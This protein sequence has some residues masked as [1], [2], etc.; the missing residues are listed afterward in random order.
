MTEIVKPA[1]N[2]TKNELPI[3]EVPTILTTKHLVSE[4]VENESEI[5]KFTDAYD[6]QVV[7]EENDPY[8]YNAYSSNDE[9]DRN[10]LSKQKEIVSTQEKK[11]VSTN[12]TSDNQG[13]ISISSASSNDDVSNE[14]PEEISSTRP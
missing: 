5:D 13:Q 2:P 10:E 7:I 12:T 8:D 11:V 4:K 9:I 14:K 1:V 3:T 6:S